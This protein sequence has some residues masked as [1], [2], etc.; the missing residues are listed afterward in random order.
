MLLQFLDKQVPPDGP[1][2][3]D[4]ANGRK[5][6]TPENIKIPVGLRHGARCV[7]EVCT[8]QESHDR[9]EDCEIAVFFHLRLAP[10][11]MRLSLFFENFFGL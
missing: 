11:S 2:P 10:G 6:R 7:Q 3:D 8:G 4:Q 9:Q 1:G 5:G